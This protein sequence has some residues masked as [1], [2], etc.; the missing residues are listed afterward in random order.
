MKVYVF[1]VI[2]F[3]INIILYINNRNLE[4]N[5][6][7]IDFMMINKIKNKSII[8]FYPF[9]GCGYANKIPTL[10]SS[11]LLSLVSLHPVY[12]VNW[13]DLSYYFYFPL[14]L[15]IQRY[16]Y[17]NYYI[18]NRKN[19]TILSLLKFNIT[20][21][22]YTY[23]TFS[24]SV[25]SYYNLTPNLKIVLKQRQK[26]FITLDM[27]LNQIFLK[28]TNIINNYIKHFQKYRR[29]YNII[30]VHIRTG[31][32]SD[33]GEKDHRFFN[34]NSIA[35][36]IHTI[37]KTINKNNKSML[38]IISDSTL[39]REYLYKIYKNRV[40]NYTVPGKICHARESMHGKLEVNKCVVKLIA[41][42]YIL[43]E[44]NTIIGSGS[45]TYFAMACKRKRINYIICK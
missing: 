5:I 23:H 13:K 30:G 24:K 17:N 36:Y 37:N 18:Y 2:F 16:V 27:L 32:L 15:F 35:L 21:K 40:V 3:I 22:I 34:N 33:F 45:S 12:I 44:C 8:L 14:S 29:K 11:I 25:L 1:C 10:I 4:V 31:Y 9:I 42:N 28:P 41:E 26:E 38:Y 43:S 7:W 20:I 39:I 19:S 6:V